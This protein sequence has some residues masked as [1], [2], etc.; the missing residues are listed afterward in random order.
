MQIEKL[1]LGPV[2]TNCY[3][4][5][6]THGHALVIDPAAEAESILSFIRKHDLKIVAYPITHGHVDHIS[7]L[8]EVH[9]AYPAP[10]GMHPNDL[11]WAFEPINNLTPIYGSPVKPSEIARSYEDG[12]EWTDKEWNYLVLLTPGHTPGSVSFYFPRE[13]MLFS[14]DVLFQG[15]IG[16]TDLPGGDPEVLKE[17]LKRLSQLPDDTSVY[18]GHGPTTSIGFE[19]KENPFLLAL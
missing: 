11:A 1:T 14:G 2:E 9:A 19:K 7:A 5:W 12:Q 3:V 17:S 10:I 4:V 18:P 15:S 8:A 6:N 16:R 13:K